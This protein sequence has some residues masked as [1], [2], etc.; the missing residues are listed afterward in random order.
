MKVNILNKKTG[1]LCKA[2]IT[3]VRLKDFD[4]ITDDRFGEFKWQ[5]FRKDYTGVFKLMKDGIILGLMQFVYENAFENIK[6]LTKIELS[7]ENRGANK[8]YDYIA[9]CLIAYACLVSIKSVKWDM[10]IYYTEATKHIYID[11][12][13]MKPLNEYYV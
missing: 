10:G 4:K 6:E 5:E 2:T 7:V 1:R 8:K 9:G 13:G 12:Y 11:K 3:K